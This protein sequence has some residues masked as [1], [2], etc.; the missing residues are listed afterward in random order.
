MPQ[1]GKAGA[2]KRFLLF[3]FLC[4]LFCSCG[5]Q[6]TRRQ[7]LPG[8]HIETKGNAVILTRERLAEKPV[9]EIPARTI[10]ATEAAYSATQKSFAIPEGFIS[11]ESVETY[12]KRPPIKLPVY[13]VPEFP[14]AEIKLLQTIADNGAYGNRAQVD[15]I[16]FVI[17]ALVLVWLIKFFA[18]S[19]KF[20]FHL[21]II[22]AFVLLVLKLIGTI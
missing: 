6:I 14:S 22:A 11:N 7:H 9:Q 12:P 15:W 4:C 1:F 17:A 5:I 2:M 20:I 16:W 21:L 10:Y 13:T 3:I 8:F 19:L 18:G